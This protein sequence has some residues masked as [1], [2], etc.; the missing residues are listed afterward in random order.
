MLA[1]RLVCGCSD[2]LAQGD[3]R[4]NDSFVELERQALERSLRASSRISGGDPDEPPRPQAPNPYQPRQTTS[5]W[6]EPRAPAPGAYT[7]LPPPKSGRDTSSSK[8]E[9]RS[10]VRPEWW[11]MGQNAL[12]DGDLASLAQSYEPLYDSALRL[13]CCL[14]H[15]SWFAL[16]CVCSLAFLGRPWLYPR[17]KAALAHALMK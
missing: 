7:E 10:G 12:M 1:D 9:A 13:C 8:R 16:G 6:D 5:P 4:L 11:T 15:R 17:Q 3:R 14:Q 2:L